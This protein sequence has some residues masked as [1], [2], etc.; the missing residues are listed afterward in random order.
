ME[1][2]LILPTVQK[3]A[4]D[5]TTIILVRFGKQVLGSKEDYVS[6]LSPCSH[7]EAGTR[8]LLHA[9]NCAKHGQ[10]KL[11]GQS[12]DTDVISVAHAVF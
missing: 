5:G 12:I 8:L 9:A 1:P 3:Y 10:A 11:M 6:G 4:L 2:I 7:E